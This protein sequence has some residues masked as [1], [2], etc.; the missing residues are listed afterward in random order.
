MT[1]YIFMKYELSL[2][3]YYHSHAIPFVSGIPARVAQTAFEYLK[4]QR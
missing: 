4:Y 2:F 3:I 1:K